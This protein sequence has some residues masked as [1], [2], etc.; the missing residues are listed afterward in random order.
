IDTKHLNRSFYTLNH[1]WIK[2]ERDDDRKSVLPV[3]EVR[4]P[5]PAPR[6]MAELSLASAIIRL[7]T[8]QRGGV[9]IDKALVKNVLGSFIS[10]GFDNIEPK[11]ER[12]QL[13][14]TH[15]KMPFLT[16][17]EA[18]SFFETSV[19]QDS[20]HITEYLKKVEG[21]LREEVKRTRNYLHVPTR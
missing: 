6:T 18:E 9:R 13:Y 8:S 10:L 7:I 16:A 2:S 3:S 14:R 17:T 19:T 4:R 15:F 5:P 1:Y 12:V 11:V 20:M 21:R